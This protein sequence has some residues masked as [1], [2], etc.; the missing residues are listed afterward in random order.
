MILRRYYVAMDSDGEAITTERTRPYT[1]RELADFY[2]NAVKEDGSHLLSIPVNV[3]TGF[4][5]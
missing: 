4:D 2:E 3:M 1:N 5:N